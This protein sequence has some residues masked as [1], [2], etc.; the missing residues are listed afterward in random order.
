MSSKFKNAMAVGIA[1]GVCV[2]GTFAIATASPAW[3][4]TTLPNVASVKAAAAMQVTDVYYR[5]GYARHGYAR[6]GYYGRGY[7]GRRYYGGGG[8]YYNPGAA[9]AAGAAL[10]LFGAAA[11]AAAAS[12]YYYGAPGYYGYYPY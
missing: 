11:G 12:Q 3:A 5:R 1:T 6:H 7:Y 9:A 8:G 4:A 2:A 10:G